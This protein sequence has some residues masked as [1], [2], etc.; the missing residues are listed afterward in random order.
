M[1]LDETRIMKSSLFIVLT[2]ALSLAAVDARAQ[3]ASHD[4]GWLSVNAGIQG[5]PKTFTGA[6]TF[7]T[8]VEDGTISTDYRFTTATLFDVGGGVRIWRN[9][10]VGVSVSYFTQKDEIEVTTRVPHPFFFNQHRTVIGQQAGVERRE[11]GAHVHVQWTIPAGDH[12]RIGVFGGPSFI[13]ARQGIVDTVHITETY[14]YDAATFVS[15]DTTAQS[16]NAVGFNAGVDA[17]YLFNG[18]IG[19]GGVARF[20]RA[21]ASFDLADGGTVTADLGG[22]Q[23]A[24]GLR[25]RF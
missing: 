8:N 18:R 13:T 6:T 7:R 15:A 23:V 10:G 24:A 9:L 22:A 21:R 12:L 17:S 19:V 4:G 1:G 14:P 5:A 25:V 16:R 2:L 20:S 3:A 11:I